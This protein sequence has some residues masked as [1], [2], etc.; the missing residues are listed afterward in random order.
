MPSL[1]FPGGTAQFEKVARALRAADGELPAELYKGLERAAKPLVKDAR[2][3]ALAN[4]P[5]RGGLNAIVAKARMP[6]TRRANGIRITADGIEQLPLTN[7][8]KVVH[9]TYGRRPRVVQA[10]PKAR[11]WFTK[12]LR[13]GAPKVRRE[14]VKAMDKIARRAT[15]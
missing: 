11:D 7:Q 12:P 3:S 14:L 15:S 2:K 4:L 13:N 9:P 5:H 10:I 1:E 8:G 6:V